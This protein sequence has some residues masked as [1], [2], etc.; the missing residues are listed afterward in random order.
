[1]RS[2]RAIF[3]TGLFLVL[4]TLTLYA[5]ACRNGFV[6]YDDQDYVSENQ[7]VLSGLS[8]SNARWALTTTHAANW[9]PLTWLSLQVDSQF[10]PSRPGGEANPTGYVLTNLLLHAANTLL[11]FLV[12]V[13]MT[14]YL[15]RSALVAACF[16]LHPLHVESVAWIA[17]RKD[18]LSGLFW[19]LTLLAYVHYVERPSTGRYLLVLL[20]FALG[21]AAKPMLV[22]LPFVL[23]LLDYW[24]LGRT[25]AIREKVPLFAL[26]VLGC[27][28]TWYA[29]Q[30]GHAIADT[31]WFPVEARFANALLTYCA[32]LAKALWPTNLA[33][34]YPHPKTG[35]VSWQVGAAGLVLASVTAGTVLARKRCPYLPVGWFWYLGTLVPVIGLVQVGGQA[36]ADRY[37]YLPLIGIFLLAVW[38]I[39]DLSIRWGLQ[40][41]AVPLAALLL[42]TWSLYSWAQIQTWHD[43]VTLWRHALQVTSNNGRAHKNLGTA[44]RAEHDLTGAVKQ[45]EEAVRIDPGDPHAYIELGATRLMQGRPEEALAPL[46]KVLAAYP[47]ISQAHVNLGTAYEIMGRLDDAIDQYAEAARVGPPDAGVERKWGA[48]LQRRGDVEEAFKHYREALALAPRDPLALQYLGQLLARQQKWQEAADVAQQAAELNPQSIEAHCTLAFCLLKLGEKEAARRHYQE[49]FKIDPTWYQKANR[50][51]W[52]QA[53][54]PDARMRDGQSALELAQQACAANESRNPEFLDTLAAALAEQGHFDQAVAT[55]GQALALASANGQTALAQALK[56]RIAT[57]QS[58]QPFRSSNPAPNS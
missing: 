14:G 39:A 57:Y 34:F 49:A 22:T 5:P 12:C 31:V 56:A 9:H 8:L 15:W 27:G 19:M 2:R 52:I 26:S 7:H 17:E 20:A 41:L 6:N 42:V 1:V 37:T 10:Y 24:P 44:L 29:Q 28:L 35:F 30:K 4:G 3:L 40:R 16:A 13:R 45:L 47:D 33:A 38:G 25:V 55:A 51:A 54:H 53:T 43:G 32:Y 36:M 21:L 11:L 48:A 58:K 23:L 46:L 18:V 50:K